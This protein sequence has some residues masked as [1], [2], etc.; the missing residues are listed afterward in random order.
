MSQHAID[1]AAAWWQEIKEMVAALDAENEHDREQARERIS[2]S[3]LSVEVRDG[4]RAPGAEIVGNPAE[5]Y[6]ILLTTGGPA[7]RLYGHLD[8][9]R[10]DWQ[11]DPWDETYRETLRTFAIQ[12][13]FCG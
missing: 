10:T 1:N 6:A 8:R 13:Y 2:E 9:Y 4:W 5:E 11:P 7:L 3:V 12:F